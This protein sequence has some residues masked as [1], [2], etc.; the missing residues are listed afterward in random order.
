MVVRRG[1][2][3][4]G[5]SYNSVRF[6]MCDPEN[7]AQPA[8]SFNSASPISADLFALRG[9]AFA[10]PAAPLRAEGFRFCIKLLVECSMVVRRGRTSWCY[11]YGG[12]CFSMCGPENPAQ[13]APSFNSASPVSADLFALRSSAFSAPAACCLSAV[14]CCGKCWVTAS[15]ATPKWS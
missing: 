9:S 3:S 12:S 14:D 7:P 5:R 11:S 1:R 8:P 15:F 10:A 4:L 13:P 6:S 2:T